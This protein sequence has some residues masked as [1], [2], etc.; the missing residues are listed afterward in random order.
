MFLD[1]DDYVIG[2]LSYDTIF[3]APQVMLACI[4]PS[5]TPNN[6]IGH[7]DLLLLGEMSLHDI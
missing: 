7:V 5:E 6:I 2:W 1:S 4:M 3:I